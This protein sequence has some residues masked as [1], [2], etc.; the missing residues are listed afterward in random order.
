MGVGISYMGTKRELAL[1]VSEV[2]ATCRPG[3]IL[4]VFSGMCSV[5]ETIAST[6]QVWT[7]DIQVFAFQVAQALFMSQEHPLRSQAIADRYHQNF[8]EAFQELLSPYEVAL[9]AEDAVLTASS[10]TEFQNRRQNLTNVLDRCRQACHTQRHYLFSKQY[11]N[12]FVGIRQ[13][14]EIDAVIAAIRFN[15]VKSLTPDCARWLTIAL[16]R[17]MLRVSN[18]TGHFAQY[19]EPKVGNYRTFQRQRK[20]RIWQEWLD[21]ND[22]LEPVGD[23]WWRKNNRVFNQDSLKLLPILLDDNNKPAVIYADPPYT[24]DQ[25]SRY[26]HLLETLILYDYPS[27]T[28]KG[29]YRPG[30]FSTSFSLKAQSALAMESL[31]AS[32]ARLGSDI[33]LSY[34][35]NG[36]LHDAGANPLN[37]L[38]QYYKEVEICRSIGHTHS[39][40][41]ASKGD[42]KSSVVEMIYK[43]RL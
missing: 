3:P 12:S 20:R 19:L 6:R 42:V 26:Y 39:T 31:I 15:S 2:V 16:G 18:S 21:A 27:M 7:N 32:S 37:I 25:Y 24:N 30:R 22:N 1:T 14:L 23:V 38:R 13:A 35:S 34:P 8:T 36:L 5:G 43:G 33:V 28:G 41:G 29:L 10:F 9:E 4:D 11:S 40:F 17:S